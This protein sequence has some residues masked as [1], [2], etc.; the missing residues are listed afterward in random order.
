MVI[1][2]ALLALALSGFL[3]AVGNAP[4][5]APRID[6]QWVSG[7]IAMGK[8]GRHGT[9]ARLNIA[10]NDVEAVTQT[11]AHNSCDVPTITT[12]LTGTLLTHDDA[13]GEIGV[14]VDVEDVTLRPDHAD[15]VAI[16]NKDRESKGCG[17]RPWRLGE[18]QSTAGQECVPHIRFPERGDRMAVTLFRK[19]NTIRLAN[20]LAG[21]DAAGDQTTIT[22]T[23]AQ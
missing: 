16:W 5:D 6:G 23:R 8:N 11:Y 21:S 22:L 18:A 3:T 2:S 17:I 13:D 9:V 4:G 1:R 12:R 14:L 7:C 20:P 10:G 15:V 19:G